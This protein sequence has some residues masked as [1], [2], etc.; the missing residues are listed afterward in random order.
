MSGLRVFRSAGLVMAARVIATPVTILVNALAARVLGAGDFG[1]LYQALTFSSFVFLFVEWGQPNVLVAKV[2]TRSAAVGELLGSAIACRLGASLIAGCVVPAICLLGGYDPQFIL[3]LSLTMLTATFGTLSGACQDV[4]RGFE[5]AEVAA[6]SFLGWQMLSAAVVVPTLL[7]GGG[8][9]G[10]LLAQAGAAAAGFVFLLRMLPRLQ[11]PRLSVAVGTMKD[12]LR[13]GHPFLIFGLVLTA[14]PLIDAAMLSKLAPEQAMGWYA[15]ARKLVGALIF[16]A[17]ALIVALYPTLCRLR[18]ES[19]E[20]FRTSAADALYVVTVAVVPV[21][22]G[23]GLFPELGVAVFG[24]GTFGPTA[25]D[26]RVL[27]PYVFLVYFSMPLGSCLVAAGR[28]GGWTV[29]QAGCVAVSLIL[30]PPLII[31]SQSRWGNGGLGVCA[32]AVVSEI[33]VVSGALALLPAGILAKLPRAKIGRVLASAAAM[34]AVAIAA[35][36]LAE[37]PRA[38]LAVL[39]YAGS[40]QITGGFDFLKLRSVLG[41]LRAR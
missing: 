8:I 37:L 24:S 5:R 13:R 2:A 18:S 19:M 34:T 10:L 23:C 26:L 41:A 25:G 22:L 39:A 17:S 28:E 1:L 21:A 6:G 20:N 32:A 14:Q 35:R 38:C 11:V 27:A 4:L 40:L 9:H 16:P 33:L 3:V 12:L 15:A 29:V 30:D 36:P 7:L 31:W